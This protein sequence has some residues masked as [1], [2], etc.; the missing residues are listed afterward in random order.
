MYKTNME[1][2]FNSNIKKSLNSVV[3]II[4]LLIKGVKIKITT[5]NNN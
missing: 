3:I 5:F 1:M 4:A 2:L